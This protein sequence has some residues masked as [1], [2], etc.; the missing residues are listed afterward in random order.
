MKILNPSK[1]Y[2]EGKKKFEISFCIS[3][4]NGIKGESIADR[5]LTLSQTTENLSLTKLYESISIFIKNIEESEE[6]K[7]KTF[8]ACLKPDATCTIVYYACGMYGCT[9]NW[10]L[11]EYYCSDGSYIRECQSC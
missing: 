7:H 11:V 8:L 10:G 9:G 4:L 2:K 5:L 6:D 1:E 3:E